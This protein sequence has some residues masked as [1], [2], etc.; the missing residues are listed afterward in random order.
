[1]KQEIFLLSCKTEDDCILNRRPPKFDY[2]LKKLIFLIFLDC[3]DVL[4]SEII[5]KKLKK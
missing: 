2:F 1:M 5:F 4:I 3:F